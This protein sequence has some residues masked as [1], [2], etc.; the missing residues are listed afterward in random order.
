M[1]ATHFPVVIFH[2]PDCGTSRNTLALIKA[3][4]YEP[5]IVEY[6]K[7]GW[8]RPHLL[9]LFAAAGVSPREALRG[10]EAAA[11]DPALLADDA[12]EAIIIDA[13]IAHP[14]LVQRPFVATPKGVR[15][16]RPRS[17][18]AL[19]VLERRPLQDFVKEDGQIIAA[20][21]ARHPPLAIRT[22]R[23]AD[24]P[25]IAAIYAHAVSTGT[26]SYELV[27][28]SEAEMAQR[29]A[30]IV[31]AGYPYLVAESDGEIIGYAYA[32]AF[33]ARPAYCFTAENSVYIAPRHQARGGGRALM[34]RLI[35]DLESLGFRQIIAVIGD[36]R[37]NVASI[38]LHAA[39]GFTHAG[40]IED[41]GFK[42]DR[43]LDTVLMQ[44][45]LNGGPTL[46]P[47]AESLPER[48]FQSGR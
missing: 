43:W 10:K 17:E 32:S 47:D 35:A 14:V 6:L 9:A 22:A 42:F 44:K 20:A 7:A 33:R 3:A 1:T 39:L 38:R 21:R 15:L 29:F 34:A 46:P 36:G 26:A 28:P 31:G 16:C 4:G 8:T 19:D 25:A 27:P 48:K 5:E 37:K 18:V 12:P 30:A 13:M 23:E 45:P 2:N 41:S 11:I 40:L 24:I